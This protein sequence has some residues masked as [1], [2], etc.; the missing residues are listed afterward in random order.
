M[1]R[2]T[3]GKNTFQLMLKNTTNMSCHQ[4][5]KPL[6]VLHLGRVNTSGVVSWAYLGMQCQELYF[7][8]A[9]SVR[10]SFGVE[11]P[12][13]WRWAASSGWGGV[14]AI[15]PFLYPIPILHTGLI[16]TAPPPEIPQPTRV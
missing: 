2:L 6:T 11:Q 12:V 4:N 3:S 14:A 13:Q 1:Y 7:S 9:F 15:S 10:L 5:A 16:G 8:T